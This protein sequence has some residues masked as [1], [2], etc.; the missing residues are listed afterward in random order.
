[1]LESYNLQQFFTQQGLC[2]LWKNMKQ[3]K[4]NVYVQYTLQ[5]RILSKVMYK[6]KSTT[7]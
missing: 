2:W 5:K 3:K 6:Q 1:M 4:N 7:S